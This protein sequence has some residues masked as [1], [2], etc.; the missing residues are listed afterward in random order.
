[1]FSC[2][3]VRNS[4]LRALLLI[5]ICCLLLLSYHVSSSPTPVRGDENDK[6]LKQF[7]FSVAGPDY[8]PPSHHAEPIPAPRS[9]ETGSASSSASDGESDWVEPASPVSPRNSDG[10]YEMPPYQRSLH[11]ISAEG[12][13]LYPGHL[14]VDPWILRAAWKERRFSQ[15]PIAD[16]QV[17][18]I[19]L[20]PGS[21][22]ESRAIQL[23]QE[24]STGIATF[25]LQNGQGQGRS[26]VIPGSEKTFGRRFLMTPAPAT[27][28]WLQMLGLQPQRA[29]GRV[30]PM[31]FFELNSRAK[32]THD[33]IKLLGAAVMRPGQS[34]EDFSRTWNR[35][36]RIFTL[37]EIIDDAHQVE[38]LR[39]TR[40]P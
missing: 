37:K 39:K 36:N 11:V 2:L 7:E 17:H 15:S 5:T 23:L 32:A 31:L 40:L 18:P 33:F 1:M 28:E 30:Q 8:V 6:M 24:H 13:P 12:H 35:G 21:L 4:Q 34:S 22:V 27:R 10:E 38:W 29:G 25:A 26:L 14:M 20:T 9:P 19:P 16:M 3:K